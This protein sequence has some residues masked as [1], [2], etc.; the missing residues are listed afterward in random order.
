MPGDE[1]NGSCC[2]LVYVSSLLLPTLSNYESFHS[3]MLQEVQQ[4]PSMVQQELDSYDAT[5]C[6]Y[7][8]V[9]RTAKVG[10]FET[11]CLPRQKSVI[12]N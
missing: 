6:K 1:A 7:L 5:L 12:V 10:S 3:A 2:L 4:W 8:R 9:D 11:F